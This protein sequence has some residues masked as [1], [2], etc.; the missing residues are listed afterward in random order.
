MSDLPAQPNQSLIDGFRCLEAITESTHPVGVRE[1]SRQTGIDPT[2]IYRLLRTMSHLRIIRQN[3]KRK[4][5]PGAGMH[6]L[7]VLS[8][9]SS[10][11]LRS[12]ILPLDKLRETGHSVAMGF[13]WQDHVAYF[14]HAEPE[15][16]VHLA[17]ANRQIHPVTTSSIGMSL[18]SKESDEYIFKLM[19]LK[20]VIPGYPDGFESLMADI[21]RIRQ[22]GYAY[23]VVGTSPFLATLGISL[24]SHP[25]TALA[26]AGKIY[27]EDISG[28]VKTISATAKQI[29]KNISEKNNLIGN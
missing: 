8:L 10:N 2:K 17:L 21:N 1:L 13:L 24:N 4:Y 7:S 3:D 12:A 9:N 26:L 19:K 5:V 18:L 16:P 22:L 27:P 15:T 20:E 6:L 29:D 25:D 14:Y 23:L 28:L 11:L